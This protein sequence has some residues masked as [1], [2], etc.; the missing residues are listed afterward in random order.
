MLIPVNFFCPFFGG[1]GGVGVVFTAM[2]FGLENPGGRV[3]RSGFIMGIQFGLPAH[4]AS[5]NTVHEKLSLY[6]SEQG[7]H[8]LKAFRQ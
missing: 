7:L 3:Q 2:G 5:L 1:G 4:C 6:P 8:L